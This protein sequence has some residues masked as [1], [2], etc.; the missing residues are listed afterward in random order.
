[1]IASRRVASRCSSVVAPRRAAPDALAILSCRRFN[2]ETGAAKALAKSRLYG[3]DRRGGRASWGNSCRWAT[4]RLPMRARCSLG[5]SYCS[6]S[7]EKRKSLW[8]RV[9]GKFRVP[10]SPPGLKNW[11]RRNGA[12]HCIGVF[13]EDPSVLSENIRCILLRVGGKVQGGL[14]LSNNYQI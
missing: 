9:P 14:H 5:R 6:H 2:G 4:H 3:T 10:S 11:N 13:L 1:M 8:I 12:F 7:H